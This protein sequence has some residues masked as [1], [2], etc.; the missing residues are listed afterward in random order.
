MVKLWPI[1]ATAAALRRLEWSGGDC[2]GERALAR[3]CAGWRRVG[4]PYHEAPAVNF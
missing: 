4:K 1:P 3:S 2:G